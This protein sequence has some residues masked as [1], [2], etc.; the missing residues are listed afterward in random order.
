MCTPADLAPDGFILGSASPRRRELLLSAGLNFEV[1][2]SHV[3]ED[4]HPSE[5]PESYVRRLA[6]EKARD[7]AQRARARGDQRPVLAADTTVVVDGCALGKPSD[8]AEAQNMLARLSGRTHQVITG[9]CV[10]D[11]EKE[12]IFAVCTAVQF[13]QLGAEE[14]AWYLASQE[15]RDKAG[16]YAIQGLAACL[17]SCISG[18]YTNVVGLPLCET[19]AALRRAGVRAYR[20]SG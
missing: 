3:P 7:V 18:S 8:A 16:A 13:K 4:V 19:V 1:Q 15:W 5:F 14:I 2:P 12:Q 9:V 10:I 20:I 17:V 6:A 11:T